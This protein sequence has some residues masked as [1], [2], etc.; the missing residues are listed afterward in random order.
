MMGEQ[1]FTKTIMSQKEGGWPER[2]NWGGL[3]LGK[4]PLVFDGVDERK[5]LHFMSI[6]VTGNVLL[7]L[8]TER[9]C[10][11]NHRNRNGFLFL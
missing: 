10:T 11:N 3:C 2:Q 6:G 8:G 5:N 7:L 4:K 1:G 9:R